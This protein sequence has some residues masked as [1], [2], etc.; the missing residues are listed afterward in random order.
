MSGSAALAPPTAALPETDE[1]RLL[2]YSEVLMANV[3]TLIADLGSAKYTF[4]SFSGKTREEVR[5]KQNLIQSLGRSFTSV[6][7]A[8]RSLQ[9]AKK[10]LEEY[11]TKLMKAAPPRFVTSEEALRLTSSSDAAAPIPADRT[12]ALSDNILILME[13]DIHPLRAAEDAL[14]KETAA[15]AEVTQA[16]HAMEGAFEKAKIQCQ[17]MTEHVQGLKWKYD[18]VYKAWMSAVRERK[19]VAV[20]RDELK[21]RTALIRE[22]VQGRKAIEDECSAQELRIIQDSIVKAEADSA[23]MTQELTKQ[24]ARYEVELATY[25]IAYKEQ[26]AEVEMLRDRCKTLQAHQHDLEALAKKQQLEETDRNSLRRLVM[27]TLTMSPSKREKAADRTLTAEQQTEVMV[28]HPLVSLLAARI[29]ILQEQRKTIGGILINARGLGK[30][31]DVSNAIDRI[32]A[33]LEPEIQLDEE[34]LAS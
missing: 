16:C 14:E 5:Q 28:D 2:F 3:P 20:M 12:P 19:M 22:A 32:Q 26:Q 25:Q 24:K 31:D 15:L 9:N 8:M 30:S 13:E 27:E 18:A 7:G 21:G 34:A 29:F 6:T 4:L 17:A 10:T 11:E 23:A 33:L 1:E